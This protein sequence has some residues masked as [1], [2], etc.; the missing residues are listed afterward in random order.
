MWEIDLL[1]VRSAVIDRELSVHGCR[2][3]TSSLLKSGSYRDSGV[4][5]LQFQKHCDIKVTF[6]YSLDTLWYSVRNLGVTWFCYFKYQYWYTDL[7][8]SVAQEHLRWD[9]LPDTTAIRRESNTGPLVC[10]HDIDRKKSAEILEFCCLEIVHFQ[11]DFALRQWKYGAWN[12][13]L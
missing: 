9:A 4:F 10:V 1:Y 11:C 8:T 7:C 6:I 2:T 12:E 13:L 5:C 3:D